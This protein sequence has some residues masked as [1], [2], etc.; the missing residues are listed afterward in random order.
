[1]G[2]GS[3]LDLSNAGD[4]FRLEIQ[5]LTLQVFLT[6]KYD[7]DF[8]VGEDFV[9]LENRA[10][11]Q[12]FSGHIFLHYIVPPVL[13]LEQKPSHFHSS[14]QSTSDFLDPKLKVTGLP[15]LANALSV[16]LL[17]LLIEQRQIVNHESLRF[18]WNGDEEV[19]S[20]EKRELRKD[21]VLLNENLIDH[22]NQDQYT[23]IWERKKS[24]QK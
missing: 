3:E 23:E 8:F 15:P 5:A 10:E 1:M 6:L 11:F 16:H 9:A 4:L 7:L 22:Y 19:T 12:Y 24:T 17:P 13:L 20:V 18:D 14:R 21:L 2:E